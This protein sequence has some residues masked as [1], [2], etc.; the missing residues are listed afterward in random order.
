MINK[1]NNFMEKS[2]HCFFYMFL[3]YAAVSTIINIIQFVDYCQYS[4]GAYIASELFSVL[5]YLAIYAAGAY[6]L[7][8]KD[9]ARS[10]IFF[11]L[12]FGYTIVYH[13]YRA[14]D[15]VYYFSSMYDPTFLQVCYR[16]TCCLV[17]VSWT[18]FAVSFVLNLFLKKNFWKYI[19][20]GGL[21]AALASY[22]LM[23][24]VCFIGQFSN[25]LDSSIALSS[26]STIMYIILMMI[27]L[28][29]VEGKNFEYGT[30]KKSVKAEES[31]EEKEEA[32]EAESITE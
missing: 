18:A 32:K 16:I 25:Q 14:F 21:L 23:F 8:K 22:V 15:F 31:A 5:W 1:I 2:K 10:R 11:M 26:F 19:I 30:F 13:F 24:V 20:C 7:L 4:S 3:V 6:L 17:G 12:M 28:P 27:G 9:N 29:L